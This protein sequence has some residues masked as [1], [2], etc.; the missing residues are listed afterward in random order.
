MIVTLEMRLNRWL[1][2]GGRLNEST[3]CGY[4]RLCRNHL[5]PYLGRVPLRDLT[6]QQISGMLVQ[7]DPEL[8]ECG[9]SLHRFLIT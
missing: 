5:I 3:R 7:R 9:R 6:G 4:T 2:N 8:P 1:E